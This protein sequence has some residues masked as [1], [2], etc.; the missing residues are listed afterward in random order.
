[1][2]MHASQRAIAFDEYLTTNTPVQINDGIHTQN[3]ISWV[4]ECTDI[5]TSLKLILPCLTNS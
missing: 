2:Q 3:T 1:M 5:C 4:G